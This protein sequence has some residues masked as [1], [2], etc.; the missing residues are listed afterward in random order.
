MIENHGGAR[1][2][3]HQGV[4]GSQLVM[5]LRYYTLARG[6]STALLLRW[7]LPVRAWGVGADAQ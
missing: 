3:T 4:V 5:A 2:D 7:G 1:D 6:Q